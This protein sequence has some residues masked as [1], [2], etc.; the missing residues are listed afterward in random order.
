MTAAAVFAVLAAVPASASAADEVLATTAKAT[1]VEAFRGHVVWSMWDPAI[2]AYRL[3]EYHK[4]TITTLSHVPPSPVPFD[5]DLG[6][7]PFGGTMAVYSRCEKPVLSPWALTGRRGCDIYYARLS[8]PTQVKLR[9]ADSPADESSPTVWKGRI[10]FARTYP[11]HGKP[12]RRF[13]YWR[14][15]DG[16]GPSH[17]LKRGPT[18][19]RETVP[20]QLDMR[21]RRV[22]YVWNFEFGEQLRLARTGGGGRRLVSIPGSGAAANSLSA[23]GPTLGRRGGVHWM[24]A[25]G[26]D[27]PVYSEFRWVDLAGRHQQRA[28]TRI[29]GVSDLVATTGFARDGAVSSYVREVSLDRFEIHR[30][31]GLTYEHA[32]PIELE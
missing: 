18:V 3:T 15:F 7:D 6:P 22:T 11:G 29:D 9:S 28:T 25:I 26:G 30:T 24:L 2:R 16:K 17:R 19:D 8:A 4:G 12:P 27:D 21:G 10:A 31:T 13:L 23:Q 1:G 20:D 32:P 5:V 14:R